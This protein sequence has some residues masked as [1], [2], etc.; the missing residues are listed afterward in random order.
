MGSDYIGL[1]AITND[2]V[3]F[4]PHSIDKKTEDIIQE[5]LEVRTVKISL[6]DSSLL[7]VFGKMNN[8]EIILPSFV[9]EKEIKE[10]EKEMKVRIIETEHALGNLLE[11][12]DT[13]AILSQTLNKND[14]KQI[15]KAGLE[16][17]QTNIA[18]TDAVGSSILLTNKSFLVN[19]NSSMEEIK[20]IQQALNIKG[21]SSTA[22]TGD[23]FV[24]NSVIANSKGILVGEHTTGHELAR[25]EE[26]LE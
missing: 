14:V 17:I 13:H 20:K 15:Q 2:T 4:V 1:F 16:I 6:Y 7:A 5:T 22:N 23:A 11:M 9:L 18:K 3:C 12:N 19:P 24:R 8:N 26:A 21:G 10:I 25:I